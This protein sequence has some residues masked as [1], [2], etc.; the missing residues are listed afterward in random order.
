MRHLSFPDLSGTALLSPHSNIRSTEQRRSVYKKLRMKG[1]SN[2]PIRGAKPLISEII[3]LR[4]GF[5]LTM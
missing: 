1:I 2:K 3:S 4:S 5:A